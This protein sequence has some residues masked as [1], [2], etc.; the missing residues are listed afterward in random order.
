MAT[1][2]LIAELA[3]RAGIA[4]NTARRYVRRF[5]VFFPARRDGR[6]L[7]YP[8]ECA[9]RLARIKALYAQGLTADDIFRLLHQD[10]AETLHG[11]TSGAGQVHLP[12]ELPAPVPGLLLKMQELLARLSDAE[13][14]AQEMDTLRSTVGVLWDDYKAR[15]VHV[16]VGGAGRKDRVRIEALEARVERLE[17]E[18]RRARRR[19]A[20]LERERA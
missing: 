14:V 18:L 15:H 2:L 6:C 5:A 10:V 17:E 4:E 8:A 9:A 16:P 3:E 1:E 20:E 13:A 7:R 19:L 12:L 11:G